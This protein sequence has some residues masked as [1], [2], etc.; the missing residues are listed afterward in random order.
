MQAVYTAHLKRFTRSFYL[1]L[2]KE[3][4]KQTNWSENDTIALRLCGE[5]L[6]AER[7]PLER[8]A[9]IRTGEPS[10]VRP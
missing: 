5:K 7:V 2:P 9:V 8:L 4:L 1:Q 6:T 10:G 3:L